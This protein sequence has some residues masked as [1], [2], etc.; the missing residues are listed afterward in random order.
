MGSLSGK[1]TVFLALFTRSSE[2]LRLVDWSSCLLLQDQ[3]VQEAWTSL[4]QLDLK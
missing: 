2:M 3:T 1:T 4:Q